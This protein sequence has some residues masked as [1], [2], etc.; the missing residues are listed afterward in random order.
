[1]QRC[2]PHLEW[3][4]YY[5]L[6]FVMS[7]KKQAVKEYLIRECEK[8]Y[9]PQRDSLAEYVKYYWEH[10]L[11]KDLDR[12]WHLDVMC[13]KLEDVYYWKIKR[14][15]INVPPRSLKTEIV[16]IA[17]PARCI[18]K[19]HSKKFMEISYSADIPKNSWK[20]RSH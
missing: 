10:E 5:W 7:V 16:S 3:S 18:G 4:V 8:K 15:A 2:D 20:S 11:K 9:A 13:S 19:D 1:M 6:F 14:L 12:N 17:F